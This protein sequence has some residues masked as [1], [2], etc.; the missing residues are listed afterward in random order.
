MFSKQGHTSSSAPF[1]IDLFK[2][3]ASFKPLTPLTGFDDEWDDVSE[4]SGKILYQNK[5]CSHVFKNDK[6]A[7]DV[8]G[9]IFIDTEGRHYIS[10]ESSVDITFPYTP[11]SEYIQNQ[12]I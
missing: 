3:I 10:N 11:S 5:R 4:M 2:K 7:F 12:E 1:I 6:K 8:N 9:K